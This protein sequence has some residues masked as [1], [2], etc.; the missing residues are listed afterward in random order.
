MSSSP[1]RTLSSPAV[2]RAAG[3]VVLLG[4]LA[5]APAE[6]VVSARSAARPNVILFLTDDLGLGDVGAYRPDAPVATPN[7]DRLAREGL[8]FTA[9]YAPAAVCSPTRYAV[10][11]G[12]YAWRTRLDSG[13]LTYFDAPLIEPRR[14]TVAS[15]LRDQG[16]AT[17]AIGKWHLGLDVRRDDGDG[18]A[19]PDDRPI[20]P[21]FAAPVNGGP[22]DHGFDSYFGKAGDRVRAF[23]QDRSFVGAPVRTDD[24]TRFAV[25]G[26]DETATDATELEHALEFIERAAAEPRPFFIY[27]ASHTPHL[28]HAVPATIEGVAVAGTSGAGERGDSIVEGDVILGLLL[29]RLAALGIERNT[30]VLL[31]SDNGPAR[32]AERA[33]DASGGLRGAKGD[34]WEGGLRVPFIARWGDGTPAGSTIAPGSETDQLIGLNDLMATLGDLVGVTLPAD[35]AQDSESFLPT[36]LGE[37]ADAAGRSDLVLHSAHGL[38]AIR[39]GAWKL[40]AG[41]GSGGF[42]PPGSDA[43]E[44]GGQ[45]YDLGSDPRETTNLYAQRPDVVAELTAILD[46]SRSDGHSA[47]RLDP[48]DQPGRIR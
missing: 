36:L 46:R 26:W 5:C 45:L 17:A 33:H 1:S 23:I 3:V 6:P 43:G 32:K 29:D 19:R 8:R 25:L 18:V 10:L 38:F 22:L 7:I 28:P 41:T 12:R 20:R 13:V 21:D 47:R 42:S 9:A 11:T 14:P 44:Q 15:M 24:P 4:C 34:I 40:I 31:A 2:R 16:Y 30:L 37:A 48:A 39:K 27:Y 35:A